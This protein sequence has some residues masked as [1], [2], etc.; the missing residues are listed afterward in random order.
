MQVCVAVNDNLFRFLPPEK[1]LKSPMIPKAAHT[2]QP[3]GRKAFGAVNKQ[4]V[5]TPA[6]N[7]HEK[8]LVKPQVLFEHTQNQ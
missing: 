3:S 1:L 5:Q 7:V 4:N 2:P 8:K 6:F